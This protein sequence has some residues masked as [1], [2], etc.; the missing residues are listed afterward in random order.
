MTL[1]G[2]M[3][4]LAFDEEG[5]RLPVRQ[6]LAPVVRGALLAELLDG[7]A[8]T[9]EAGT[10][11]T[12]GGAPVDAAL[13]QAWQGVAADPGRTWLHWVRADGRESVRQVLRGLEKGGLLEQSAS[14]VFGALP[15]NRARPTPAGLAAARGV[16]AA[17]VAVAEAPAA[18][19]GG[20]PAA[21]RTALLTGLAHVGGRLGT[22]LPAD[23]RRAL[24]GRLTELA[25][26]AAPV[27]AAVR[28][29]VQDLGG[30]AV[31]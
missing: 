16:R 22:A 2:D 4:L 26:S 25:E 11:G 27:S 8:L 19:T 21:G 12:A 9:D 6:S 17:V 15:L 28:R 24:K 7:G 5:G 3:I 14:R 23:R 1:A 18:V 10:A 13:R 20:T 29:A 31:S 30:A